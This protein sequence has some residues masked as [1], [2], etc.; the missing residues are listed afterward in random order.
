[1]VR[2]PGAPPGTGSTDKGRRL[3]VAGKLAQLYDTYAQS[4]PEMLRAWAGGDDTRGDGGALD[5]DVLWQAELF[6]RLRTR[7]QLPSTPE[8]LDAACDRLRSGDV[9]LDLPERISVFGTSRL[10]RARLQV[11]AALAEHRDVHLWLHHASPA[12]WDAVAT[13]PSALRRA[14]D[15]SADRLSNPLL[16]SLSR[17]VRELQQLLRDRVPKADVVQHEGQPRPQTLLGTCR[18]TWPPTPYGA[19]RRHSPPTTAASRC[20]R[21]TA[22]PVRWRCCARSSCACSPTTRPSSRGTS[23]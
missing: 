23:S 15:T 10:S 5:D 22:V 2:V 9:E 16:I 3:R 6:R 18:P 14:D 8:V 1:V 20:T 11:L 4:R 7:V 17:D 19:I 13:G 21:A 12:L